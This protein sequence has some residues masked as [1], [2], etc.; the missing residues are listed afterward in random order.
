MATRKQ[1]VYITKAEFAALDHFLSIAE[2]DYR[3]ADDQEKTVKEIER[4]REKLRQM[5]LQ[6]RK[7]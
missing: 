4:L 1:R 3:L 7:V 6:K 2:S 5:E